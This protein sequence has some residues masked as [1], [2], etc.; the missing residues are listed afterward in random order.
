MSYTW[1]LVADSTRAR[2]FDM[3]SSSAG[4]SELEALSSPEGRLHDRDI[5]SDLPGRSFDSNKAGGRHA[6]EPATDPKQELAIEFARTIARH[7]EAA[8]LKKDFEQLAIV[9]AP[10]FLGL[11]REQLNASCSKLV[12]FELNKNLVQQTAE[13]IRSHLPKLL[14]AVS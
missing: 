4:L 12:A 10:T 5:T 1:V 9:A 6:M 13:D 11:L 8:R 14:P 7:L 2:I 3:E